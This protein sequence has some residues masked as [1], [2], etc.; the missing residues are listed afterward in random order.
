MSFNGSTP[1]ALHRDPMW[2]DSRD[3]V[4]WARD[5]AEGTSTGF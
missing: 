3:P 4:A 2:V 5:R 1:G